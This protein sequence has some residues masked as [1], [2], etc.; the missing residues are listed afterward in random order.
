MPV[1]ML[2]PADDTV[3]Q[4]IVPDEDVAF[5]VTTP[6]PQ[7]LLLVTLVM[8]GLALTDATTPVLE[9]VVHPFTVAST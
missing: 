6:L 1:A 2:L 3:Y 7:I 8:V 5:K 4:L 9:A